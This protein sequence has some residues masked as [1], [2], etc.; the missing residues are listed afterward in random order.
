V[1]LVI[2]IKLVMHLFE[3]EGLL[4]LHIWK[5]NV[6]NKSMP[7][8]VGMACPQCSLLY[9]E[10]LVLTLLS[11]TIAIQYYYNGSDSRQNKWF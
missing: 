5:V 1:S 4:I 9:L 8:R 6:Y 3:R 7:R 10:Y 2:L 11:I